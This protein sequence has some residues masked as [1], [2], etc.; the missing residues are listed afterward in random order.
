MVAG[1]RVKLSLDDATESQGVRTAA[2]SIRWFDEFGRAPSVRLN[3]A[4]EL[5][6]ED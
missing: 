6:Q 1:G 3:L 2:V 5:L 4:H